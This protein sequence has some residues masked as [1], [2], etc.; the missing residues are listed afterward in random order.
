M[1][2]FFNQFLKIF[3]I[4]AMRTWYHAEIKELFLDLVLKY[5]QNKQMKC[6]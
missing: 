6:K 5:W 1:I 2:T 4:S 3:I